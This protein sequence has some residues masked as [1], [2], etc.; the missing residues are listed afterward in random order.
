MFTVGRT[1]VASQK[2]TF[3]ASVTSDTNDTS[4]TSVTNCPQNSKEAREQEREVS[5]LPD[6]GGELP[7]KAE[8]SDGYWGR[9][10]INRVPGV[11]WPPRKQNTQ[12][13]TSILPGEIPSP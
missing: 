6:T 4:D 1:L 10:P 8:R 9:D 11:G 13:A 5:I 3:V 2:N 7:V 12:F